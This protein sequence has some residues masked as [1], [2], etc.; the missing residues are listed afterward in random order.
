MISEYPKFDSYTY[1]KSMGRNTD[2]LR[3]FYYNNIIIIVLKGSVNISR[4]IGIY[5]VHILNVENRTC[6]QPIIHFSIGPNLPEIIAYR[7]TFK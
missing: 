4:K 3:T 1:R 6:V 7:I 2:I 5:F